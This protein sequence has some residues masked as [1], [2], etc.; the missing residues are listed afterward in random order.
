MAGV[1]LL[2]A[3]PSLL[4]IDHARWIRNPEDV[5]MVRDGIDVP[6]AI[7]E[8]VVVFDATF[9]GKPV[10]AIL[11]TGSASTV[12]IDETPRDGEVEYTTED[13]LGKPLKVYASSIELGLGGR[14]RTVPLLRAP[15]FYIVK[16]L[17]EQMHVEL[18]GLIGLSSLHAIHFSNDRVRVAF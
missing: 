11:D 10:H 14:T 12:T 13:A 9:D 6:F 2:L 16:T 5:S 7:H 15:G 17:G 3:E 8:G 18:A 1:D 4:D